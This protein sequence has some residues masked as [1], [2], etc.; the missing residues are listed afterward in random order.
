MNDRIIALVSVI[1]ATGAG[2]AH[3]P[4]QPGPWPTEIREYVIPDTM[5][6]PNDIAVAGDGTVWFSDR[7]G[8]RIGSLD[9]I[10]GEI[11]QYATPT[12]RSAPYG[13]AVATD[14]SVWYAGSQ[15][16]VLGR[17][18]PAT[19]AISEH[20][21]GE[22]GP[23]GVVVMDG[24]IWFTMRRSGGYGWLDPADGETRV[25]DFPVEKGRAP[26]DRGPYALVAGRERTLWFTTMGEAALYRID[27]R[28][29]SLKRYPLGDRGWARR[30]AIGPSG[31]IWYTNFPAG[32]LGRLDPRTGAV[33]EIP[34]VRS[35]ADPYG[36][37]VD[38][39]GRVWFNEARNGRIMGYD[40]ST[41]TFHVLAIPTA[42]ATARGMAI[43]AV[44]RRIWLPLSGTHRIGRIDLPRTSP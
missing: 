18:D 8:S 12:P 38:P 4:R 6:F 2:C 40:P 15:A 22:G 19:G 14:G 44:H 29:G 13:I 32:R 24:R 1:L 30:I 42:A 21:V 28:D 25:F 41:D 36:I 10:T 39:T 37:V 5:A 26:R 33:E 27:A 16:G 3:A 20:P 43:D 35:P 23:H 34:L 11:R 31:D 17:L 7:L 9:P